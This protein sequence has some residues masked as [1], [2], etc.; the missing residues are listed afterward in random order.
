LDVQ[1]TA[2]GKGAALFA[3][4]PSTLETFQWHGAHVS[5]L[6]PGAVVLAESPLCA[7]QAFRWGGCAYGLQYHVEIVATTVG[8]WSCIPEYTASLERALG[9]ERAATLDDAV[10]VRLPSFR[11]SARRLY[12]NLSRQLATIGQG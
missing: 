10:A 5:T 11:A 8:E 3:G 9:A 4:F 1:L 2:A 12:D 7:V 6:P